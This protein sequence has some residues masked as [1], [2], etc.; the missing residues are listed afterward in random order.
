MIRPIP[1]S[2]AIATFNGEK[3]IRQQIDSIL[4][5]LDHP[6]DEVVIYDD[7]STDATLQIICEY[8]S[9]L[10]RLYRH[11]VNQGQII[12]FEHAIQSCNNSLIFLSDQDDIW[13]PHK[14]MSY[15]LA[16]AYYPE[17]LLFY[18]DHPAF[19]DSGRIVYNSTLDY[20][21]PF[22]K[23]IP[24]LNTRV[25][26]PGIAFTSRAKSLLLPFPPK[27][28]SHDQWIAL[29]SISGPCIF[30]PFICQKYR[31]H[32]QQVCSLGR[33]RRRPLLSA[34]LSRLYMCTS[35]ISRRF[36]RCSLFIATNES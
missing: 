27:I 10:I 26:G 8:N 22:K 18:S 32:P 28:S 6:S 11:P 1:V 7:A 31:L 3:Y 19:D 25:H 15:Y 17:A 4:P 16:Y 33:H 36:M 14:V 20:N 35:I 34:L 21:F 30:L 29:L 12:T 9:P 2:I 5:Q 23:F 13:L 24:I